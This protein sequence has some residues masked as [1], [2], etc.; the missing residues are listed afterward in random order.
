MFEAHLLH[1]YIGPGKCNCSP[2]YNDVGFSPCCIMTRNSMVGY[3]LKL[4]Q[5]PRG[6]DFAE[7]EENAGLI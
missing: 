2:V 4:L 7:S 6:V 3:H 5:L 1:L